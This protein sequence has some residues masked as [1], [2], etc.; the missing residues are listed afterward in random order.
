MDTTPPPLDRKPQSDLYE[1]QVAF[2]GAPVHLHHR[3]PHRRVLCIDCLKKQARPWTG[4][5]RHGQCQACQ[6][7]ATERFPLYVL[8]G[9]EK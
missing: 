2:G 7:R 1:W 3:V 6:Q 8:A 5:T 4:T 9:L